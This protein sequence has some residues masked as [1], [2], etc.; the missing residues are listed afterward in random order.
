MTTGKPA[1]GAVVFGKV[2]GDENVV[3]LPGK[4][5]VTVKFPVFPDRENVEDTM[6]GRGGREPAS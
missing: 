4:P 5:A 1:L 6:G 2:M 3:V